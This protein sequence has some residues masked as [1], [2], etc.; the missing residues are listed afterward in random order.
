[1]P[2]PENFSSSRLDEAQGRDDA[3]TELRRVLQGIESLRFNL[4]TRCIRG[5]NKWRIHIE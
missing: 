3:E 4:W 1:M 2:Y 5:L